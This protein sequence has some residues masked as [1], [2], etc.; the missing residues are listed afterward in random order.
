MPDVPTFAEAGL[1]GFDAPAWY[2]LL[3]PAGTPKQT[4][5]FLNT[6]INEILKEPGTKQRLAQLGAEP[7]GGT[8][9]DFARFMR[10]ESA[11]WSTV[12]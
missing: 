8:P 10:S 11:R 9:E 4:I 6:Q 3:V 5:Q 2:G 12:V 1:P 7:S